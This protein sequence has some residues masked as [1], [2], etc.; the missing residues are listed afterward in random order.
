MADLFRY[1]DNEPKILCKDCAIDLSLLAVNAK[2]KIEEQDELLQKLTKAE[3][4]EEDLECEDCNSGTQVAIEEE[5]ESEDISGTEI[6]SEEEEDLDEEEKKIETTKKEREKLKK[7]LGIN[8]D[9]ELTEEEED[10]D[11]GNVEDK[12]LGTDLEE[13]QEESQDVKNK[14]EEI[15]YSSDLNEEEQELFSE[16]L[17]SI[18][19]E[20][21]KGRGRPKGSKNK[22][23][24]PKEDKPR[25]P[26]APKRGRPVGSKNKPKI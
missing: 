1:N 8:F 9:L 6:A 25:D 23:T 14:E 20:A 13:E 11:L 2:G 5:E 24:T 16:R 22:N 4:A 19:S 12:D 10:L 3:I 21:P 17:Q 15:D 7:I 26:N 18:A